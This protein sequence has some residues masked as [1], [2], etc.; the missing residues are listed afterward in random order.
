MVLKNIPLGTKAL[1]A[2]KRAEHIVWGSGVNRDP[3]TRT[4]R[5]SRERYTASMTSRVPDGSRMT[6]GLAFS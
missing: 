4:R 3:V 6:W 1:T 2:V 5:S